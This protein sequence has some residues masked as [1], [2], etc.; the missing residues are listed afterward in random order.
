M[1]RL[2][3]PAPGLARAALAL[4]AA[5]ALVAPAPAAAQG[6]RRRPGLL[7]GG[8]D[9]PAPPPPAPVDPRLP[10]GAPLVLDERPPS[11]EPAACSALRPVCV[12][13]GPGV[14]GEAALRAL[15]ALER[16]HVS[17]FAALALPL[18]ED[19]AGRGAT[20]GLDLYLD[21]GGDLEPHLGVD[22]P[23]TA[24]DRAS[25][26]C[27][28]GA[29][30][31][32]APALLDR[33]ATLCLAGIAAAGLDAAETPHVRFAWA[34]SLWLAVGR[35]TR[36]DLEAI[37]EVQAH[38]ERAV[39]D[40]AAGPAALGSA[41]L[42]E[43]LDEARGAGG[44]GALGAATLALSR[45]VTPPDAWE[46][47]NE[48]DAADVL[49][50]SLGGGMRGMAELL[51]GFAVARAFV[52]DRDTGAYLPGT[53]AFGTFGRV[54]IDWALPWSTLPRRVAAKRPVEPTGSVYFWLPL[55][56]PPS[57]KRLGFRAEW[58]RPW[59]FV[60]SVLRV[61][62]GGEELGRRDLV[63]QERASSAED[64]V[65]EL[66]G[67]AGVLF[68]GTNLGGVELAFPFDPDWAPFEP[69][70]CTLYVTALD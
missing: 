39:L 40:R 33:A 37:D 18:P 63:L 41:L 68:V 69:A 36:L 38:P 56:A 48:P 50:A 11:A 28:L 23:R 3:N 25:G 55:D 14:P 29:A 12:H 7:F 62:P 5:A 58:E 70:G 26:F 6:A 42:F 44:A 13:R 64:V 66:D 53:A 20:T 32:N 10:R 60:W 30:A 27:R 59:T 21:A 57:G 35:P 47:H 17:L 15:A 19:D 52:G 31:T 34:E 54:R 22:P 16:A 61:G 46:W 67:A 43:W 45:G 2:R 49:R 9:A 65:T 8:S 24:E 1:T 51:T 4:A